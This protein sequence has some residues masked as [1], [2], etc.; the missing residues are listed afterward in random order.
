MAGLFEQLTLSDVRGVHELIAGFF[1]PGARVVLHDPTH[2]TTFRVEDGKAGADVLGEGEQVQFG[3]KSAVVS[4][5]GLFQEL[6]VR[7]QRVLRRPRGA[8]Q[9]LQ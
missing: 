9:P 5:F 1:V 7:L 2:D 4:P 8:I 6:Q 3:S